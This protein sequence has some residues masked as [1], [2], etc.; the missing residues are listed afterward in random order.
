MKSAWTGLATTSQSNHG[1]MSYCGAVVLYEYVCL[2]MSMMSSTFT[3]SLKSLP[4][5]VV[6]DLSKF[7]KSATE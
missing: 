2:Y 5:P 1:M 4:A 3:N 7:S 6:T